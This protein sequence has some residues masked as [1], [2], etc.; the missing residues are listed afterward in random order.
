[1]PLDLLLIAYGVIA[2]LNVCFMTGLHFLHDRQGHYKTAVWTWCGILAAY[3]MEGFAGK[4]NIPTELFG[5]SLLGISTFSLAKLGADLYKIEIPFRRL[6]YIWGFFWSAAVIAHYV[7]KAPFFVSAG[8][9]CFGLALP[10]FVFAYRLFQRRKDLNVI[11]W[12]FGLMILVQALHILD[13]PILRQVPEGAIFGFSLGTFIIYLVATLVPVVIN[14]RIAADLNNSLEDKIRERTG[15][16]MAAEHKLVNAAKMSALGEMAG[17]I[18]HEINNPLA[19]IG[20]LSEQVQGEIEEENFDRAKM[21][22][23]LDLMIVT[24][25]RIAQIIQGLRDFSRDG[26]QDDFISAPIPQ[27]LE[28]TLALCQEKIK[29]AHVRMIVEDLSPDLKLRCRPVQISQVLLNII[30]NACDAVA[31]LPEK[32]IRVTAERSEHSIKIFITDSGG[33]VPQEVRNK[34][35]DPF[36]TTKKIGQGTGLGLSISK[37]IMEAHKGSLTIDEK[38]INTRFVLECPEGLTVVKSA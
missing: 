13:Y 14:V 2:L 11:D 31:P 20:I 16:L 4:F 32:W 23:S 27:I 17:G 8:F 1:M 38:H 3:V 24:V 22:K 35:F 25:G 30:S 9:S 18:A 5:I 26:S 15:Q 12:L 7:F 21:S 6:F 34:I 10:G 19:I 28:S 29:N 36:F 37:G 33:G